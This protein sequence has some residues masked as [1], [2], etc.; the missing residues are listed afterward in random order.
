MIKR[1]KL[2]KTFA[3]LIFISFFFCGITS[4]YSS[5]IIE[6][7]CPKC[8]YIVGNGGKGD[9]EPIPNK[10]DFFVGVCWW[11]DVE[12]CGDVIECMTT[13]DGC[14]WGTCLGTVGGCNVTP[15]A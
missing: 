10:H 12:P 15:P 9:D 2:L 13:G 1:K 3:N 5:V 7:N 14:V 11:Y 4:T 6:D 8:Y